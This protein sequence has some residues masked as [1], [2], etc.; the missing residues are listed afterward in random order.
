MHDLITR[1]VEETVRNLPYKERNEVAQELAANIQDMLGD[2]TSTEKV[3]QTLLALGPPTILARKYRLK[4]RC[5][6]G[7][8]T[9]DLYLQILTVVS[10]VVATVTVVITC[11]SIIFATEPQT[12]PAIIAKIF[13]SVFSS[14][15]NAFLWVTITFAILSN[16]KMGNP[17]DEWDIKTLRALQEVPTHRIKRSDSIGD[18]VG[19]SVFLLLLVVLYS[20]PELFAVYR[21]GQAPVPLFIAHLLKPYLIIW[22]VLTILTFGVAVIKFTKGIW[23]KSLFILSATVDLVGVFYFSFL[24]TRFNLYNPDF[25]SLLPGG[26]D[27]WTTIAK[28]ACTAL[29][30]LTLISM[31]DDAYTTFRRT[32]LSESGKALVR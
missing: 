11:I 22:M 16:F 29:L 20:R 17:M 21:K 5:L 7:P 30:V 4:E 28:T 18:M 14:L 8:D 19:V 23:T 9:F 26:M 32:R 3:E 12:I 25:L 31:G 27:R 13:G 24:C 15:S 6:I 2:D 10:S 1:Y